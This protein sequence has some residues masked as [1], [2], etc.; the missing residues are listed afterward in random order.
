MNYPPWQV[1]TPVAEVLHTLGEVVDVT[2]FCEPVRVVVVYE[3][4]PITPDPPN[5]VEVVV[6]VAVLFVVVVVTLA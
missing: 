1:K 3:P 4:L 6:V 2:G 5:D